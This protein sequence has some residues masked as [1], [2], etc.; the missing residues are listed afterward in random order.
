MKA[1]IQKKTKCINFKSK[2]FC[3]ECSRNTCQLSARA[4]VVGKSPQH[5]C[6][7]LCLHHHLVLKEAERLAH[8]SMLLVPTETLFRISIR[9]KGA[10][11]ISMLN[12]VFTLA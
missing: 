3:F 2:I 12:H 11:T 9:Q 6:T 4:F 1:D 8:M 5:Q 7:L 10:T